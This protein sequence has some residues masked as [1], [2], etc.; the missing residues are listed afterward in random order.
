MSTLRRLIVF[1][2]FFGNW[3]SKSWCVTVF[4]KYLILD[5]EVGHLDTLHAG[6]ESHW[7]YGCHGIWLHLLCVDIGL[8]LGEWYE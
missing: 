7:R 1:D 3:Y 4:M 6:V 5:I 8:R 2:T